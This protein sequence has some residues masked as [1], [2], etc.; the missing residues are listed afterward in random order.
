MSEPRTRTAAEVA[1]HAAVVLDDASALT[2]VLR[3]PGGQPH[4]TRIQVRFIVSLIE[5]LAA[6]VEDLAAVVADVIDTVDPPEPAPQPAPLDAVAGAL[7]AIYSGAGRLEAAWA[8]LDHLEDA[9]YGV[10]RT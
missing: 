3:P 10:V 6:Q 5:R 7:G 9:G 4:P 2:A 1:D 8:L